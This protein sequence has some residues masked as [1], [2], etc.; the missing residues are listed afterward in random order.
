M[1]SRMERCRAVKIYYVAKAEE[2]RTTRITQGV[3]ER[4]RWVEVKRE[5]AEDG[6][7]VTYWY[8][9]HEDAREN[10]AA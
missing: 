8:T 2:A 7:V 5:L 6:Y 1:F 9:I 4:A 3:V 10:V